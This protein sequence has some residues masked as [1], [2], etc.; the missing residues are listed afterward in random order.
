MGLCLPQP[1]GWSASPGATPVQVIVV[2]GG[3]GGLS[4]AHTILEH[5]INVLVVD[6]SAFFGGNSTKATSG[7][8]GA[9]T[10]TQRAHKIG[11][12]PEIFQE[13]HGV[14]DVCPLAANAA[15]CAAWR[16]WGMLEG[17]ASNNAPEAP[18]KAR[19]F[20]DLRT[21]L[22]RASATV[23][24]RPAGLVPAS[25]IVDVF[26]ARAG[27]SSQ[28]R[29]I[30]EGI[31]VDDSSAGAR[32][33]TD[34]QTMLDAIKRHWGP[35]CM[36]PS[37]S[38]EEIEA[39]VNMH[40]PPGDVLDLAVPSEAEVKAALRTAQ[41]CPASGVAWA[42]AMDPVLRSICAAFPSPDA[43]YVGGC[44]DDMGI[45]SYDIGA[46]S[47]LSAPF[48]AARRLAGLALQATKCVVVPLYALPTPPVVARL[49]EKLR[50]LGEEWGQFKVASYARY[51]GGASRPE[52][53]RVLCE[54]CLFTNQF[55]LHQII[56]PGRSRLGQMRDAVIEGGAC[57]GWLEVCALTICHFAAGASSSRNERIAQTKV[58][59]T[60]LAYR[61]SAHVRAARVPETRR[62]IAARRPGLPGAP[63]KGPAVGPPKVDW[64]IDKFGV[65]LS[66]VSR[67]GGHSMPRTH[68]GK[69][70]F[71]G[72]TITYGLMEKLEEIAEKT[73]ERARIALKT[74]VT[75]LL[76]DKDG[77]V[78]G[79]VCKDKDGKVYEEHGPVVI[80]TGG[81]GAD[82]TADSLLS[83]YRPDLAHLPTTNGEHCTGDGLKMSME[84]GCDMVDLEWVQ[85]HPTGLVHPEEPD[86][87]VK[88]LAAEALRGVGG[89]LLDM[90]GNRFCNE[91]GRRDYVTGMMWKNK[92]FV[93]G[94]CTGFFLCLNS[95]SSKEIEWHCKHYKG[96]GIMKSFKDMSEMAKF[97]NIP[98][99]NIDAIFKAY[100]EIADKQT[101][102]P[103]NGPYEAYG[104][105]K[106]WDEWGKKFFHNLPMDIN[107][108]FHVAIVTPVIHYC[109]GGMSINGDGEALKAD[110]SVLGGLYSAGEAAG[111]IH[112]NNR[113]GGNSLLD[114]VV[115]G[116]VSG[117][118]AARYLSAAN[119]KYIDSV[120]AG[121]AAAAKL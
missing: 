89:V 98:I 83:K 118:A 65:D 3:L 68:R 100:N 49:A 74:Q 99:A 11:D 21:L 17:E 114:C 47:L 46:M 72:M 75:K 29:V 109:M 77:N 66:L 80:A 33:A 67:L 55:R 34:H 16:W 12:S 85:V 103:E 35:I 48:R 40:M 24:D 81:F 10:K 92:G 93:Q 120:K 116:R 107:D 15:A 32:V 95:K 88:F 18:G 28:D 30:L 69:E 4:A 90:N 45:V 53:V 101:K 61:V 70:R 13:D 73:P 38:E 104:G 84:V 117:R 19:T 6:K 96:R 94:G 51:L 1:S 79:C 23:A 106:S 121:T 111:G 39:Y 110:G 26:G 113:L 25:A 42:V 22:L 78:C 56:S 31:R 57:Q 9:L 54:E 2:G 37:A 105:G 50:L 58:L 64:I 44:A 91:L 8:N 108:S 119:I 14:A 36:K 43:G 27:L 76:T 60:A 115:Y 63:Q 20:L 82:F 52:L 112:G 5:G 41:G 86:A 71:P 62:G 97:Y 7:I 59:A 87:K 102:D